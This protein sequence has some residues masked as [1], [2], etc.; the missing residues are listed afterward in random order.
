MSK[1]HV[2]GH[3][4]GHFCPLEIFFQ[5]AWLSHTT[6]YGRLTACVVSEKT[7]E[8]ILRKFTDRQKG[9]LKDRWKNGH[10]LFFMTLPAGTGV[11]KNPQS[12]IALLVSIRGHVPLII[13]VLDL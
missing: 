3:I 6:I 1:N 12:K 9:G 13:A 2:F 5:K 4:F 10:S 7:N 8:P 11:A